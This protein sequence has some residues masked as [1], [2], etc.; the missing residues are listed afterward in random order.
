MN[1]NLISIPFLS[2]I[3]GNNGER[4]KYPFH[5]SDHG[6]S[7]APNENPY[8][9]DLTPT[10][11]HDNTRSTSSYIYEA[12]TPKYNNNPEEQYYT[13]NNYQLRDWDG[14]Y[15]IRQR[16]S[17]GHEMYSNT[18]NSGGSPSR[19]K[20]VAAV[21]SSTSKRAISKVKAKSK[22]RTLKRSQQQSRELDRNLTPP[23]AKQR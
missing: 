23:P 21:H 18:S 10:T 5:N 3:F 13:D 8:N 9:L 12:Y 7:N 22:T 15:S 6:S 16:G 1:N 4:S 14:E 2:D 19:S 11:T 17:T 20:K